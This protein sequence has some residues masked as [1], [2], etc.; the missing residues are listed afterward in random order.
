MGTHD[1]SDFAVAFDSDTWPVQS[2]LEF[3]TRFGSKVDVLRLPIATRLG[4]VKIHQIYQ[5]QETNYI[6]MQGPIG[7]LCW[8]SYDHTGASTRLSRYLRCFW[9]SEPLMMGR[10]KPSLT[11][12]HVSSRVKMEMTAEANLAEGP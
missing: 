1:K 8:A 12:S 10:R 6:E 5:W 7:K 2:I 9:S 3:H 4:I 11:I